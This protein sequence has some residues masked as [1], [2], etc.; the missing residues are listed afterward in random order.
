M[1]RSNRREIKLDT[2]TFRSDQ[3]AITS[4][5]PEDVPDSGPPRPRALCHDLG[6]GRLLL[7]FII[8]PAVEL[9]LLI[10]VGNRIGTLATLG[11]IVATG[12]VGAAL[13][14]SQG[15]SVLGQ[16]Q[17]DLAEGR[18]PA[19]ALV[20]GA[21]ILVAGALLMT[22]GILTDALGFLCLLPGF[23]HLIKRGLWRR[24]ESAVRD[25]Q[26]RVSIY[27][28]GVEPHSNPGAT[29]DVESTHPPDAERKVHGRHRTS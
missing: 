12:V 1:L 6:V 22:P 23:R 2:G 21:I 24:F 26:I 5:V 8:V 11:L 10:E 29:I 15:L 3:A 4:G 20:D 19:G 27:A 17:R 13:A 18:L 16:V 14:R 9:A 28:D 25:Q 7:L